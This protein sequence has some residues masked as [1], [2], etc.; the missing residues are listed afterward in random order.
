MPD[1]DDSNGTDEAIDA[2]VAELYGLDPSGFTPRRDE[3]AADARRGGNHRAAAAIA[4]LRRPT[5]GAWTVNALARN[6]PDLIDQLAELGDELRRAER[7]LDGDQLRELS[8]QRRA[9]VDELARRAFKATGQQAPSAALRDEVVA[10]L[11]AALADPGV[12]DQLRSGSLARPARW[13][14]FGTSAGPGL[15]LVTSPTRPAKERVDDQE[16]LRRE[17]AEREKVAE[18]VADAEEQLRAAEATAHEHEVEAERLD[19]SLRLLAEQRADVQR[20]QDAARVDVRFAKAQLT[21]AQAG[22]GDG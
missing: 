13:D 21:K 20:K 10:T 8:K 2:A 14:G 7:G 15:A 18:R 12:A 22:L 11:G 5:R 1:R 17:A 19:E 3:L 9:L 16:R 4:R 6:D